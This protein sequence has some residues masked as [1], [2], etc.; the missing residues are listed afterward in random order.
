MA[1]NNGGL[2]GKLAQQD[3]QKKLEK[4]DINTTII[5]WSLVLMFADAL[6]FIFKGWYGVAWFFGQFGAPEV[7]KTV[8]YML[9]ASLGLV[10]LGAGLYCTKQVQ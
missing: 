7:W 10:S 1:G 9:G 3:A 5:M 4:R 8:W 6:M 2:T